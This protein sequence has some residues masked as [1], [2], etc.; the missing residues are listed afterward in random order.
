MLGHSSSGC[1][2]NEQ[3][4]PL[5]CFP[6][7]MPS[8]SRGN[9]ALHLRGEGLLNIM[10]SVRWSKGHARIWHF[11]ITLFKSLLRRIATFHTRAFLAS[12]TLQVCLQT[13]Q[14][15]W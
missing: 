6:L 1:Q 12:F 2:K 10:L 5:P 3:S 13:H 15:R 8:P 14:A 9:V 11:A 4:K 7:H